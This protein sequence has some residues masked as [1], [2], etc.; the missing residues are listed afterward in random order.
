MSYRVRFTE[1]A[2]NDLIRLYQFILAQ[3]DTNFA[4]AT[5]A[6]DAINSE[7]DGR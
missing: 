6:L 5:R 1:A 2:E 7:I 3:E 4:L